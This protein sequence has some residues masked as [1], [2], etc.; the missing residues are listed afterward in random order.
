MLHNKLTGQQSKI[1]RCAMLFHYSR[2]TITAATC[3]LTLKAVSSLQVELLVM[4]MRLVS[5]VALPIKAA[6]QRLMVG[7]VCV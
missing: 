3:S 6:H 1:D 7:L 2:F 5:I 4:A